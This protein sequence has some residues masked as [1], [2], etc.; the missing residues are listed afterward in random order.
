VSLAAG[1]QP[2]P[3]AISGFHA[4]VASGTTPKLIMRE[5]EVRAI[6]YGSM[7]L[8]SFVAVFH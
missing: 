4:L 5:S 8:E 6:G 7:L 3:A 2:P 1:P